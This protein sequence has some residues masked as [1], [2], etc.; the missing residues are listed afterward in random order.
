[1][2]LNMRLVCTIL[3]LAVMI[4]NGTALAVPEVIRLHV[5]ANSNSPPDQ[6]VKELV[7]DRIIDD[8]GPLFSK[9]EQKDVENWILHNKDSISDLASEVLKE[10]GFNYSV[11]VEFGVVDYPTRVYGNVAYPAGKYRSVRI[12]LGAGEGRNWWCLLFPPLCF[13]NE[14]IEKEEIQRPNEVK[15]RFWVIE[16]IA[17]LIEKL[18]GG[19]DE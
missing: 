9:M 13:V 14:T 8:L 1:M 18:R 5:I 19:N 16:K 11:Q 2:L 7:R 10:S 3:L 6:G 12:V 4:V 15:V 17:S